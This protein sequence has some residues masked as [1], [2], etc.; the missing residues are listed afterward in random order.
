M[1]YQLL[2][3]KKSWDAVKERSGHVSNLGITRLDPGGELL[4]DL[5]AKATRLRVPMKHIV[6]EG[7]SAAEAGILYTCTCTC[8]CC[9]FFFLAFCGLLQFLLAVF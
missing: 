6:V 1:S 5:A 2:V 3:I 9:C 7:G 8:C 4:K